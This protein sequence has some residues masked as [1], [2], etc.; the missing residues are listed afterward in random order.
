MLPSGTTVI[1][2]SNV[3]TGAEV[4]P[5]SVV[6]KNEK[7][8]SKE[9]YQGSPVKRRKRPRPKLKLR[10]A[11]SNLESI[12]EGDEESGLLWNSEYQRGYGA[13]GVGM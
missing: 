13:L 5:Q 3:E 4:G 9:Y 7:L 1:Y 11:A 10:T 2:E 12:Q 8:K 6:L